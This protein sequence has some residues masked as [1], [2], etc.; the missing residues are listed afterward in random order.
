MEKRKLVFL[1]FSD[2]LHFPLFKKLEEQYNFESSFFSFEDVIVTPETLIVG[3]AEITSFDHILLGMMGKHLE[4]SN[5]V[6][7]LLTKKNIKFFKYGCPKDKANK[8]NEY[9]VLTDNNLPAIPTL[10]AK[11]NTKGLTY[12]AEEKVGYP[13]IIKPVDGSKGRGVVKINDFYSLVEYVKSSEEDKLCLF[14][15][16]IENDGDYR[17]FILKDRILGI[18]KRTPNDPEEF[19]SNISLGGRGEASDLPED[20]KNLCIQA[21]KSY[22]L[23]IAGVDVIQDKNTGSYF[24]MEVNQAPQFEGLRKYVGVKVEEEIIKSILDT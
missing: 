5:Y 2:K 21:V 20:I 19:R 18:M 7:S 16:F 13:M 3:G 14:Q 23:D 24:I 8:L 22:D 11:L 1:N 12:Y 15:H 17:V 9:K 10:F 6:I 4:V